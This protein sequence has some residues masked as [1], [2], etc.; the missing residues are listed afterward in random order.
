MHGDAQ[1]EAEM[2]KTQL[3][4]RLSD[5]GEIRIQMIGP[6]IGAHAGPG[7]LNISFIGNERTA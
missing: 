7:T 6:V 2:L 4:N 3:K 1:E 5:L